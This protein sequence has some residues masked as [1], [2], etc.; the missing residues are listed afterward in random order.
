ML[1]EVVRQAKVSQVLLGESRVV[2]QPKEAQVLKRR[3]SGGPPAFEWHETK[4]RA[5]DG[6]SSSPVVAASLW[7]T[8]VRVGTE[9]QS[10]PTRE[11]T[12]AADS[13]YALSIGISSPKVST[14]AFR[15]TSPPPRYRR[16]PPRPGQAN[17]V[18]RPRPPTTDPRLSRRA[19]WH[20]PWP[21]HENPST[22]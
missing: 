15:A 12:L 20:G 2:R 13:K 18:S 17:I 4:P 14:E 7:P 21:P 22:P 9:V 5:S 11:S 1:I 8:T 6:S 19:C 10:I 16:G 3:K